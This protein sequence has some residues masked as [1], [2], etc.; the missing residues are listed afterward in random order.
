MPDY[1]IRTGRLYCRY[2]R[3]TRQPQPRTLR[4]DG[5]WRAI[6]HHDRCGK[7]SR[8]PRWDYRAGDDGGLKKTGTAFWYG[9]AFGQ[10]HCSR[11]LRPSA[12]GDHRQR[13]GDRS[14]HGNHLNRRDGQI[15]GTGRRKKICRTRGIRLCHVRRF[16]LQ[17]EKSSCGGRRRYR[18]RR[19]YL[20]IGTGR[21]S[22]H[23]RAEALPACI[24]DHA[25]PCDE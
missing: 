22:L 14:R 15:P 23:D 24:E 11:L 6:D 5:T 16:L 9:C 21:Q 18:L 17:K 3:L 12:S 20:F 8:L 25:G 1:W 19:G 13:A 4:R 10:S 7:L 2:L